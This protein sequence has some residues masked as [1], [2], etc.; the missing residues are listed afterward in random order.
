MAVGYQVLGDIRYRDAGQKTAGFLLKKLR[1]KD[2]RL[3][4]SW[5]DGSAKYA[6]HDSL[7]FIEQKDDEYLSLLVS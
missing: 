1:T 3:L 6:V 2:G 4:R 7:S 5:H